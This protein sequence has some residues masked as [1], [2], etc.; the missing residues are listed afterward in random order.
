M[1]L[2]TV[3]SKQGDFKQALPYYRAAFKK[4][5]KYVKP[6]NQLGHDYAHWG[7]PAEARQEFLRA[8]RVDPEDPAAYNNLALLNLKE[9]RVDE[10]IDLLEQSI[11]LQADASLPH[12]LLGAAYLMQG[13]LED[14]ARESAEAARLDPTDTSSRENLGRALMRMGR[15]EDALKVYRELAEL[16][17]GNPAVRKYVKALSARLGRP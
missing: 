14:A 7:H 5:P 10:A 9:R 8:M 17:P 15:S 2:G 4:F 13:R 6:I 12:G 1:E 11:F 3:Y 16:E